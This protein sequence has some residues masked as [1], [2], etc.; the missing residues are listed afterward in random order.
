MFS[1]GPLQNVCFCGDCKFMIAAT[2]GYSFRKDHMGKW[3]NLF[4]RCLSMG[5]WIKIIFSEKPPNLFEHKHAW[6]TK[7]RT[8]EGIESGHEINAGPLAWG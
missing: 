2:A 5:I 4:S 3:K 8:T 7:L 1:V 6:I